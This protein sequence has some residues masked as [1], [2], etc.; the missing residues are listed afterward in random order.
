[1][2][3]LG[4]QI[5][6]KE[7]L[8]RHGLIQVPMIQRDFAQ[9]RESEAEV[10][11]EFLEA[12]HRALNLPEDDSG[13]PLNLD[14]I[15]GSMEGDKETC[16]L[17]LDGQQRLTTLFLL[18]WYLAW[19]DRCWKEF[20]ELLCLGGKSR[21]SYAVRPS[22]TEFFDA[23][24]KF[25]PEEVPDALDCVSSVVEDQPWYFRH[26]RLD[27]T[28]QASLRML[29][30]IHQR[31]SSYTGLYE[32]LTDGERPAITFQLLDLENFGLSDDL[33]IKMNARGK[34]LTA[35]ETFKAR[36]EEEL[37]SQFSG[38]TK[39]LGDERVPVAEFVSLR[40]DTNWADFFWMY[41]DRD[42]N[43]YD[44]AFMNGD[45]P[46]LVETAQAPIITFGTRSHHEI[47]YRQ[48]KG[49]CHEQGNST[50]ETR[51]SQR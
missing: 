15:Y 14:F 34:P 36:Y 9:G 38:M 4:Q 29:D 31:F 51:Q 41:R 28:I 13:L 16:F 24:V 49:A 25:R 50:E 33:Y 3:K 21:F 26:W 12:L 46:N 27:P 23:L 2:N 5:V 32:R 43:L 39:L 40:M 22:S 48:Q 30:A 47:S 17:P 10:R 1:M 8:D 35:F 6:F 20:S 18:H 37:K 44:D 7:L 42:T 19:Q 45:A 11:E